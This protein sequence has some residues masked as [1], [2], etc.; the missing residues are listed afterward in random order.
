MSGKEIQK[1]G[2]DGQ[3]IAFEISTYPSL[4]EVL[5]YAGGIQYLLFLFFSN[6]NELYSRHQFRTKFPTVDEDLE[7]KMFLKILKKI[8]SNPI[9]GIKP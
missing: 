3:I 5:A 9:F 4:F 8:K 1:V 2:Q 7:L 6:I